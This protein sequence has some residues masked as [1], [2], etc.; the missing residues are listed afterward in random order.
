M[1]NNIVVPILTPKDQR[2]ASDT[3]GAATSGG[4]G[5]KTISEQLKNI[6]IE[7]DS[8]E[9]VIQ[10]AAK[11]LNQAVNSPSKP[12]GIK[13]DEM[14]IHVGITAGGSVGILGTGVNAE[15]EASFEITFKVVGA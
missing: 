2:A 15:A 9:Q 8:L 1:K 12:E 3:G 10:A 6:S 11:I 14:S 5:R 13:V 7:P 4:G